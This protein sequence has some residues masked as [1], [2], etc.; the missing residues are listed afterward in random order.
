M[1]SYRLSFATIIIH[2]K[3]LAEVVVDE[4][5]ELDEIMV[6]EYHDFLLSNLD[7]PILLLINRKYSYAY[8][9]KAQLAI[10]RLKEIKAVAVVVTNASSLMS[11]KTLLSLNEE[12][13]SKIK[14]FQDRDEALSWLGAL[15]YSQTL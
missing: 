6:A 14:I 2:K 1:K 4:G 9:F 10:G 5:V 11:T 15:Q 8:T 3:K 12:V 7:T 13:N